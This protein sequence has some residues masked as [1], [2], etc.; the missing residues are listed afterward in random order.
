MLARLLVYQ[1]AC[2]LFRITNPAYTEENVDRYAAIL[3]AILQKTGLPSCVHTHLQ[4]EEQSFA[5]DGEI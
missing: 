5:T 1:K 2:P 3:L 4:P